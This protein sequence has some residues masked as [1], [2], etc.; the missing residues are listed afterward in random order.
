MYYLLVYGWI[1]LDLIWFELLSVV[2]SCG[3]WTPTMAAFGRNR[4]YINLNQVRR[5]PCQTPLTVARY[6]FSLNNR[7]VRKGGT[8]LVLIPICPAHPV[9]SMPNRAE[10]NFSPDL[11]ISMWNKNSST[12]CI[13]SLQLITRQ[14][15][16]RR[17]KQ[18]WV[19]RKCKA[20]PFLKG[21][22]R[23]ETHLKIQGVVQIEACAG[24]NQI[25]DQVYRKI[26]I[27]TNL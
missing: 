11:L 1:K 21:L 5:E 22:V 10:S 9:S 25:I 24:S 8:L 7:R 3:A 4:G 26:Q 14:Q 27:E 13:A 18:L 12:F 23:K 17:R 15:D 20:E 2:A 16:G 6:D 19:R